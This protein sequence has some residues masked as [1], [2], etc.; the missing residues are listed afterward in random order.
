MRENDER[1]I[2]FGAQLSSIVDG[3]AGLSGIRAQ[4]RVVHLDDVLYLID[5]V[6]SVT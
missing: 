1:S 4:N 3:R 6:K 5:A 2:Y